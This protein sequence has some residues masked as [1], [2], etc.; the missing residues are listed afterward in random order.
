MITNAEQSLNS[1]AH[2]SFAPLIR[3]AETAEVICFIAF[4]DPAKRDRDAGKQ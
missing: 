2:R 1:I 4:L 3:V